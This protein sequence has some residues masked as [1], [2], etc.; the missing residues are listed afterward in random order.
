VR[1][2]GAF[3]GIDYVE[4][5][6][7]HDQ[8]WIEVHFLKDAPAVAGLNAA[9]FLI[10]GG[11][12]VRGIRVSSSTRAH[13][14]VTLVVDRAGDYSRYT[15]RLQ[16]SESD[17]SPPNGI[18]PQLAAVDLFFKIDCP[19]D[20]DCAEGCDCPLHA[21]ERVEIDYLAKD[22]ESFRRVMLDR[23]ALTLPEWR[24]RNPADTGIAL[25]EMLAWVGDALSY[26]QDAVATEAYLGTAR[27]RT[28]VRRHARLLD[29]P[30]DDGANARVW[31]CLTVKGALVAGVK[32]GKEQF[33]TR[34]Q[35]EP[36]V[37]D[38]DFFHP[39]VVEAA[40]ALI[41]EPV[42]DSP[43][44]REAHN[45]LRFYTWSDTAC[46]LPSGSTR[47]TLSGH[48]PELKKGHVLV[49][50][51]KRGPES[52][53]ERDAD[54]AHAH[55]V[56]LLRDAE[57]TTDPVE[58]ADITTL[59]WHSEDALP[60]PL[61]ISA[62]LQEG[63]VSDVGVAHG[64][65]VAADHGRT[66]LPPLQAF[67]EALPPVPPRNPALARAR[68]G[69]AACG[70]TEREP[71]PL[72]F[73]PL[74][75]SGPVTRA[76]RI[77]LRGE[78]V[79]RAFDPSKSA[80]AAMQWRQGDVLPQVSLADAANR[81]WSPQR[82]LLGSDEL[83]TEFVVE[84]EADGSAALRFGDD[85]HGRRPDEGTVFRA[86]YRVGNGARGNVGARGIGHI[87]SKLAASDISDG[88][89]SAVNFTPAAGGRDP[90]TMTDVRLKA[91]VAFRQQERA[92]T[93]SDYE[94]VARRH[95][96]V[97]RAAATFRWTGSWYTVYLTVDRKG[98]RPVDTPFR[99]E[100]LRHIDRYR[101]AGYDVEI[102]RPRFVAIDAE[103][104]VCVL[105]DYF[106]S[107]VHRALLAAF[108]R[109]FDPD[110]FTFGQPVYL[111]QI[112]DAAHEVTGVQSIEIRS[113]RRRGSE[114]ESALASGEFK[115]DR[116][117]IARLDN[118]PNFTENGTLS[119]KFGGG[120]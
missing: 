18:D 15:L 84:S 100:M 25:V 82:D 87:V 85:V 45:E 80:F 62:D 96:D 47:A 117:E 115:I 76:A 35:G 22:Y 83:A 31:I 6:A 41:F 97:Q 4:V 48:F 21:G 8:L 93:P 12:R 38:P 91:P 33:V 2:N 69:S 119:F 104:F 73:R 50:R 103:I 107:D 112:Y 13:D 109:F 74:L 55:A 90:E 9:N 51:E 64:N 14:V 89:V 5:P 106:V 39:D 99:K 23:M 1:A 19:N 26:Q 28:S 65:V 66:V 37:L 7:G 17:P 58:S 43:P 102:D 36:P 111:S 61:C 60:F 49:L 20:F 78:S 44:L 10:E 56:R 59:E 118:D 110:R 86:T 116:L 81:K 32:Q 54:P 68:S 120:R 108:R 105:Q 52:G 11:V 79:Q 16:K 92:V 24:E 34:I 101:M 67:S 94:D 98:G 71:A 3:N 75:S 95:P 77:R 113:F 72:R 70:N 46:C 30:V 40:G 29:Y 57:V 42:E 27:K 53:S 63:P 88:I 114:D